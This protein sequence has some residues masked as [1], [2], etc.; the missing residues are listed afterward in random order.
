MKSVPFIPVNLFTSHPYIFTRNGSYDIKYL[1]SAYSLLRD[2]NPLE[3]GDNNS[4]AEI[5]AAYNYYRVA[6]ESAFTFRPIFGLYSDS[7]IAFVSEMFDSVYAVIDAATLEVF[8]IRPKW[9]QKK[10][11]NCINKVVDDCE[12]YYILKALSG[13]SEYRTTYVEAVIVDR[14]LETEY[15]SLAPYLLNNRCSNSVF[16]AEYYKDFVTTYKTLKNTRYF[17]FSV[18]DALIVSYDGAENYTYSDAAYI[19]KIHDKVYA[20]KSDY[21]E[22]LSENSGEIPRFYVSRD[23]KHIVDAKTFRNY[24]VT[25]NSLQGYIRHIANERYITSNEIA[26][27][28]ELLTK[29]YG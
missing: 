11:E 10:I 22:V 16:E 17:K 26:Y 23:Y 8:I 19:M 2:G 27:L 24:L 12:F 9:A 4:I 7:E 28:S 1:E 20:T 6:Y 15:M 18:K 3:D 25:Y 13:I 21:K 5:I 14:G 29:I